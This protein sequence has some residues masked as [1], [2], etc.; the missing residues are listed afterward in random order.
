MTD[1]NDNPALHPILRMRFGAELN[2]PRSADTP[3]ER[4]KI[5]AEPAANA[6]VPLNVLP[7]APV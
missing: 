3:P 7:K 4:G 2:A 1:H 5:E 6:N